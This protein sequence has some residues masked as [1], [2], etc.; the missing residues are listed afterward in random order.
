[1]NK[2]LAIITIISVTVLSVNGQGG[3]WVGCGTANALSVNGNGFVLGNPVSC[4]IIDPT[5]GTA[6]VSSCTGGYTADANQ[7]CQPPPVPGNQV[8]CGEPNGTSCVASC[9]GGY[10]ADVN[11]ICQ[12][13]AAVPGAPVSCGTANVELLVLPLVL[14]VKLLIQIT[15]VKL[16][17]Q[18]Y[19]QL[20]L[21][22]C[23]YYAQSYEIYGTT[24][25][26]SCPAGQTADSNN[27]CQASTSSLL[28]DLALIYGF[29][30]PYLQGTTCAASCSQGYVADSNYICQ[31]TA[32]PGIDVS[33]G[34]SGNGNACVASCGTGFTADSNQI[35]QPNIVPGADVGCGTASTRNACAASCNNGFTADS[36]QICQP[37]TVPGADVSCGTASTRNA[38]A[39]SCNNGFTAD[40]NQICQPNTVPGADVSCGTS[41]T[42]NACASSC[43]N[44]FTA[45]LNNICQA[46]SNA[47]SNANSQAS[48]GS[49]LRLGFS[50]LLLYLSF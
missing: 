26:A 23:Y 37:N 48:S 10:I 12:P 16:V 49:F 2:L 17:P 4:G 19:H 25:V 9:T 6:C 33:C 7:I 42:G 14:Q 43:N 22:V 27:I 50:M 34:S 30:K 44:G 38:C 31:S 20:Q 11:Q 36:N 15:Y 5:T 28:L 3:N 39:A 29:G 41:S 47:N 24:C 8:T 46:N 18:V 32:V 1:M 21:Q 35:C 13:P 45:D 40:S